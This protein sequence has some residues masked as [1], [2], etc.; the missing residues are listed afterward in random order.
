M[1]NFN[2]SIYFP[3]QRVSDEEKSKPEWYANAIDFIISTGINC[4]DKK[5]LKIRLIFVMVIFQQNII[6]RH[7]ILI[8]VVN[9]NI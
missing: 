1:D 5:N 2:R 7:L 8:I 3:S 6:K 4:N 9:R